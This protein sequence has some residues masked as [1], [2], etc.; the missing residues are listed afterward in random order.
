MKGNDGAT[1][2]AAFHVGLQTPVPVSCH[3]PDGSS[4]AR[5]ADGS[6][7]ADGSPKDGVHQEGDGLVGKEQLRLKNNNKYNLGSLIW[8]FVCWSL[9]FLF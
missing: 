9:C 7:S 6:S 8:C 2:G 5:S 4:G 1:A 3:S